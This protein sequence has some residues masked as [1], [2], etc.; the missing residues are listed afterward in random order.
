MNFNG[1]LAVCSCILG[2]HH[3]IK[4]EI[5]EQKKVIF[6][7]ATY[8]TVFENIRIVGVTIILVSLMSSSV[9]LMQFE[10]KNY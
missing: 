4:H 3:Y 8:A 2:Q 10:N 6:V 5:E 7:H 9:D 1:S